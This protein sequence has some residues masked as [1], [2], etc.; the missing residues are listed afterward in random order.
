LQTLHI[1][2]GGATGI[3]GKLDSVYFVHQAVAGDGSVLGRVNTLMMADAGSAAGFMVRES[4]DRRRRHD[5]RRRP[6]GD[7][8]GGKVVFRKARGQEAMSSP[9]EGSMPPNNPNLKAEQLHPGHARRL[10]VPR[11]RWRARVGGEGRVH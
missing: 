1:S 2:A 8:T 11:L 6:F 9:P 10:C 3:G 4:L 7:G 5:L